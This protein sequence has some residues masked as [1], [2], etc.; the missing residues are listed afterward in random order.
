METG[1]RIYSGFFTLLE[2]GEVYMEECLNLL[3]EKIADADMVLVGLGEEFGYTEKQ[4]YENDKYQTF[5]SELSEENEWLL[6]YFY[7][8]LIELEI[9]EKA[10]YNL[11]KLLK[12]KNY[13]II[14][15]RTD[16]VIYKEEFRFA[17]ERIVTPCGGVR[18]LQCEKNCEDK[19]YDIP[20]ELNKK[21]IPAVASSVSLRRQIEISTKKIPVLKCQNCGAAL[22]FN[23]IGVEKYCEAEYLP[24]WEKYTKWLQGTL[25]HKLCILEL[26]VGM[27][28]P[29]VIRW[30]FEK[31]AYFNNK[32][33]FFRIHQK[34]YHLTEE[35]KG[36]G[37]AI[38]QNPVEF[39]T[40]SFE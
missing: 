18:K 38:A 28:Y 32:A 34:L 31:M 22:V 29:S 1:I 11:S 30:P 3:K 33:S 27:K 25:N 36:K 15:L 16:D 13:F 8:K 2:N 6:P 17:K 35:L 26:G 4:I 20:E 39:L 19:V 37:W 14:S 23:R 12:D 21:Y 40:N 24:M 7:S 5:F 10:Y 9:G